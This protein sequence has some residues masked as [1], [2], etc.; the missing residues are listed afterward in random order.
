MTTTSGQ[1]ATTPA[2]IPAKGWKEV[3]KRTWQQS[4]EDNIGLVAAGVAF[5]GFLALV[6]LLGATVL[7]YG[8]IADPATVVAHAQ[9][10]T[11]V[12]P[13]DAAKLIGEQ[14]LNVV[15]TSGGKKGLGLVV[16]LAIALFG[17]RNAAGSVI[18]A[19]NIAYEEEERRGFLKVNLLALAITAGAVV[20][21]IAAMI[22]VAA[23]GHLEKLLP[24]LPGFVLTLGKF[25]SYALLLAGAAAG[26][27]T[28]Y[29]YGPDRKK[30]KWVWITPGSVFA[31]LGWIGLTLG[32]GFY[33]ANFGN[34][35]KTYGS[36]ATVVV[37]LTWMYLSAYVL[38]FGAELNSELEH[39]TA[40]DTTAGPEQP[41]GQRGAWSA[42]HVASEPSSL[43]AQPAGEASFK[44]PPTPL[45]RWNA[46]EGRG[47]VAAPAAMVEGSAQ[48]P[49]EKS[50]H[51]YLISRAAAR[52]APL[53]GGAKIG[54]VGS[55][56]A[57]IGLSQLRR[58]GRASVGAT[59][60]VTAAALALLRRK[61]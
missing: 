27:A 38:L 18:T 10:L 33:A 40:R 22:A 37:L 23:L 13:A 47:T 3:A 29:R 1:T 21:A 11:S 9:S 50:G 5:Y 16:A 53:T 2:D 19:L 58:R 42:D 61:D 24:G 51:P 46:R 52:A 44:A 30:A 25:A 14:L 12:M 60:L 39:Q 49:H 15:A 17:A 57:T 41:L 31:A 55:A 32:F 36:L 48:P 4:S 6:P 34:Y 20:L 35:G 43:T 54:M 59:L 26:A 8:L 28:L 56:L 7:T 45:R